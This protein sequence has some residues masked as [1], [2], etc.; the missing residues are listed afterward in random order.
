MPP[1]RQK[2]SHVPSTVDGHLE[3]LMLD[4]NNWKTVNWS[5]KAREYQHSLLSIL[6]SSTQ[7][8]QILCMK[9]CVTLYSNRH[10]R[11]TCK[12]SPT[13]KNSFK[14]KKQNKKTDI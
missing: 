4:V 10:L 14:R 3:Q 2:R 8:N 9:I 7:A 6:L 5:E 11:Y 12:P 13:Y 1:K